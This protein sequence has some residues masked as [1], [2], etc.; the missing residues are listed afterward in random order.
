MQAELAGL[1]AATGRVSAG[2][3]D[4]VSVTILSSHATV[5]RRAYRL[6][7]AVLAAKP[8]IR[9][10]KRAK[11]DKSTYFAV[12]ASGAE[13]GRA[14]ASSGITDDSGEPVEQA[15]LGNCCRLAFLRGAFLGAGFLADPR[16]GYHWEITTT[17]RSWSR[18]LRRLLAASGIR[19]RLA[20]RRHEYVVYLKD[21]EGIAGWLNLVGA[22]QAL[23]SLENTRIYKDM[24]NRVNR[25]VNCETANLS[26]TI[27]A[28]VQQQEAIRRIEET[29]GLGALPP[30]LR[31]VARLRLANAEATLE[32]IGAML[33]PPLGKSGVNHRLREIRR[34]AGRL[35]PSEQQ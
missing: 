8:E 2:P 30:P 3:D 9:A 4:H 5:A 15:R 35:G 1:I 31:D 21:A 12:R 17:D 34:I 28:G 20:R 7:R 26:R 23:L 18:A 22:H 14:L 25:L 13:L 19:A 16:R 33:N 10:Q 29:T 11:L 6:L 24:K 32:E 27:N